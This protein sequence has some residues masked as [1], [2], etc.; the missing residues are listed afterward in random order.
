[1]K[2]EDVRQILLSLKE[3]EYQKFSSSL[4]PNVDQDRILG[5][6][7]PKLRTIARKIARGDYRSYLASCSSDIYEEML[8][9][10]FVIGMAD[11]PFGERCQYIKPFVRKIDNWG[12]C[13]SF[14]SSMKFARDYPNEVWDWIELYFASHHPYEVRFAIVMAIFYFAEE[15]YSKDFFEHLDHIRTEDYYVKMA[16]AWE[17]AVYYV[18][19]P[20]QTKQYLTTHKL[21]MWTYRKALTKIIES[22]RVSP[23][24]KEWI[25]EMRNQIKK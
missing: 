20:E 8:I 11:M 16:I 2:Q 24:D 13:D 17:I 5:V 12:V 25:R 19:V 23:E 18:K 9:E 10:G 15:E 14:C 7:I 3:D 6:R 22:N 4:L 21:D 1:M